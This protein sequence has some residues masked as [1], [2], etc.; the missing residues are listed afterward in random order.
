MSNP[1]LN[2]K[3]MPVFVSGVTGY[4][5]SWVVKYLL[6]DGYTVHGTVR[7]LSKTAKFQHLLD[8][9]NAAEGTLKLF[10]ADL[11]D[12]GAFKE[13]MQGC[14]VVI[15]TASPFVV[16]VKNPEEQ[17]VKPAVEGTTNVLTTANTVNTVKRVV[18]TSSCAAIYGDN[19]DMKETPQYRFDES[20]WNTSSSLDHQSYSFSKT[21]AERKAWEIAS[22][23][24][25]WD[26]LTIN[27]AFVMGPSLTKRKDSTSIQTM[28]Q[29]G[30]GTFKMGVPDLYF[31]F[32]DV[33]DVARA[34]INAAFTPTASGRH[35][36]CKK[37][38]SFLDLSSILSRHFDPKKYKFPK[39]KL[40]GVLVYLFGP[41]MGFSWKMLR[42]NLGIPIYFANDY[43][44]ED[45]GIEFTSLEKT[46]VDHFQQLIDDGL[47]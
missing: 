40:P 25:K 23:Q 45:L 44:K 19:A 34:H 22:K 14:Q 2:D 3:S 33:R 27:P 46:V 29:L 39:K 47:I 13:A 37:S 11:L 41:F 35:I 20:I 7:S 43:V 31:G 10:E 1:V 18:L 16:K 5:A 12:E 32:V 6:E 28:I 24:S 15:H 21:M 9:E 26:L 17:L 30:D 42:A 8:I 4:V 38:G 36:M